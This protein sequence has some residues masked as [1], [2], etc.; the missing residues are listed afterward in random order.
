MYN[1][2]SLPM[3]VEQSKKLIDGSWDC[4]W[5]FTPNGNSSLIIPR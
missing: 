3:V 1:G 2:T 4:A 5:K